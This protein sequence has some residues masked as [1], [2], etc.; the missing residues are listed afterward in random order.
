MGEQPTL[1][2]PLYRLTVRCLLGSLEAIAY[3]VCV[4][5]A[6]GLLNAV[7]TRAGSTYGDGA[8]G[9]TNQAVPAR[10]D[11]DA[12]PSQELGYLIVTSL[13]YVSTGVALRNIA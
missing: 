1:T 12:Q 10:G 8:A 2:P 11:W 3:E 7:C 6:D 5:T 4:R 13:E 9:K